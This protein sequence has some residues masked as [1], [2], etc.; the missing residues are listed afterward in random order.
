MQ[1]E[2]QTERQKGNFAINFNKYQ[3][4]IPVGNFQYWNMDNGI[5]LYKGVH[6]F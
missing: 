6:N 5:I 2:S 4:E 3:D 1:Q